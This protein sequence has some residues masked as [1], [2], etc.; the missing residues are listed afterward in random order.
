MP[1][2]PGVAEEIW[3]ELMEGNHRFCDGRMMQRQLRS[4]REFLAAGQRPKAIV[5]GCSD[6]RVP[7]ELVFDQSLGDLFVIRA[8]GNVVDTIALGSVEYA[9]EHLGSRLVIV[10]G[11]DRCGAVQAA[12]A[13]TATSS[14]NLSAIMLELKPSVQECSRKTGAT[15]IRDVV[16][17]NALRVTKTLVYRSAVLRGAVDA[18][19]LQILAARYDLLTGDVSRVEAQDEFPVIS[20][21]ETVTHSA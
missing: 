4:Q 12:C 9:V 1:I 7:P 14:P 21:A 2:V 6:S 3:H 5:I 17:K 16:E 20:P 10:L 18:G 8:A 13:G 11:H 19:N 15:L